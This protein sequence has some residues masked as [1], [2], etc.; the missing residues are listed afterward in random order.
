MLGL[1]SQSMGHRIWKGI[2]PVIDVDLAPTPSKVA[3]AS[4][5]AWR[6]LISYDHLVAHLKFWR[7]LYLHL[8]RTPASTGLHFL[9]CY[10]LVASYPGKP[11]LRVA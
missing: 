7:N 3:G 6:M 4:S 9:D 8:F 1:G 10:S 2:H 5:V 11:S